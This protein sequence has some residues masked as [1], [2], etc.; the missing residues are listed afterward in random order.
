LGLTMEVPSETLHECAYIPTVSWRA[1]GAP[2]DLILERWER[3]E[4][5][6]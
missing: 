3:L 6:G 5:L 4:R 2:F 1:Q